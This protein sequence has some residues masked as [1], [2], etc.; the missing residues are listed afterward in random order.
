M[1]FL[2][3]VFSS[4]GFMPHGFCYLWNAK[5]VWLHVVSDSLIALAYLFIP[6]TLIYFIRKRRDVPFNWMFVCFGLFILAC[7]ATHAMEVWTLWHADYWLSG[8]VKAFTAL[9]SVPTAILLVRMIPQALAL[10]SPEAMRREIEAR[11]SAQESLHEAKAELEMRVAERTAELTTANKVLVLEVAE[12]ARVEEELRRSEE[13]FRLLVDTVRDYAIFMMDPD[14][15][16]TSWNSG[17]EHIKGFKADEI[18]GQHFSRFYPPEEAQRG[19]PQALLNVAVAEGRCEDEGWRV[20]KDGS[21]YW[22]NVVITAVHD[23]RGHLVGFS[24]ITRDLTER[25]RAEEER[26]TLVALIENSHDF[27]GI[28]SPDGR[29]Q[30]V[31]PAGQ[32][33]VGLTGNDQVQRTKI[34]DYVARG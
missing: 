8:A 20:R 25:K 33:L 15:D 22:A 13:R 17:A 6:I 7:G 2:K 28:A 24:K 23:K 4:D 19:R 18:I 12:R 11:K 3:T 29:A 16:V 21:R 5:L 34:V 10:P 26:Q 1:D 9:V 27:I 14:G 32:Q 31:N 30:F